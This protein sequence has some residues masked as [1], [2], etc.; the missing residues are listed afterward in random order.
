MILVN[1]PSGRVEFLHNV[2]KLK[3]HAIAGVR[4]DCKLVDEIS[5]PHLYKQGQQVRLTGLKFLVSISWYHL[6]QLPLPAIA[7]GRLP[8]ASAC[9]RRRATAG[10]LASA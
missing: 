8:P 5:L 6:Q 1:T 4:Y 2:R 10:K 3:Y 7:N 9:K